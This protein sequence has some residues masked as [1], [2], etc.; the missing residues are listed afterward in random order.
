MRKRKVGKLSLG[1]FV[2]VGLAGCGR[3]HA[4]SPALPTV[5]SNSPANGATGVVVH[6]AVSVGFS[7]VMASATINT[8]TFTLTGPGGAAMTG[9]VSYTGTTATF[10]PTSALA[11]K[12]VYVATVTTG[13]QDPTGAGLAAN[14]TFSFTTGT[15]PTVVSTNP[16]NGA[17]NVPFN[18]KITATFSEAMNSTTV[19]A[20]GTFTLAVAGAGG[21]AVTGTVTYVAAT[22]TAAFAP[23]ANLLPSTQYTVTITSAAQNPAG[24]SL[25]TNAVW[26]FTTGKT[27]DTTPPTII[28]TLPASA[29]NSVPTNQKITATFSKVMDSA[30]ITASGT[31]I[32]A[33][34]GVGGA[35]VPGTV[36]YA[37][38]AATFTP[39]ANLAPNTQF[40][41]TVT[42]AA[43]DLSSNALVAGAKPNPWSF[44]TAAGPNTTAPTI[45]LT[46]PADTDINVLLNKAVNATFST[47]MDP[48]TITA[49][50]TLL[51]RWP[52]RA[53]R[54]S[55][56][57]SRTTL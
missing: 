48:V 9:A 30:T 19:T 14:F 33:V 29:A 17:I 57:T 49:P 27:A 32:V 4:Q 37:G 28:L 34:A 8:S 6:T 35:A 40:T 15:I 25:L 50:G 42:T 36:S 56:G 24:N 47:A 31:F 22:N 16:L 3:E 12:T 39:T 1:L 18:Q 46:S 26:S 7:V 13:A 45:T 23:T 52:E 5:I 38:S 43:K 2:L 55:L 11:A 44:T 53:G 51:W 20:S 41:A 10:T 21:A 54:L